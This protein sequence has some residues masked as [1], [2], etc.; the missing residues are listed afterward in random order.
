MVVHPKK[1]L[2]QHFLHDKNIARKI[3]GSLSFEGYSDVLEV[4]PGKGILTEYLLALEN[5]GIVCVEID[6]DCVEYLRQ[7]F[8]VH[9]HCFL[10]GDILKLKLDDIFRRPFAIIGNFPYNISSQIFFRVLEYRN[11][12]KEVVCMVQKEVAGRIA[13]SPGTKEYG[14][15]SVLLRTFYS[16]EN[17]FQARPPVFYP[18]PKVTSSVIRL[19][20]NNRL[21]L[22]CN[23]ELFS[24]VVKTA[25]NQRRKIMGNSLKSLLEG[26][27]IKE[28]W[29]A[30]R[31]EQLGPED[32]ISITRLVEK[33]RDNIKPDKNHT[34]AF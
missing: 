13:S 2:G 7:R 24:T 31:P 9:K 25:F 27:E 5:I 15:L 1:G 11:L 22:P 30:M 6:S 3:V 14:I 23:E 33:A 21:T 19:T 26:L 16:C 32:F 10:Q 12:V 4:G 18:S 17:L 34:N 29:L 28:S 20:R 8:D